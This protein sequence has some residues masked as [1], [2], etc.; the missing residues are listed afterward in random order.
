M[1]DVKEK[2]L[3]ICKEAYDKGMVIGS[4]GNV[5]IRVGEKVII[6]PTGYNLGKLRKEDLVE[7]KLDGTVIKGG[8][9]SQET[10]FHLAIYNEISHVE[11][12]VHVHSLASICAGILKGGSE[13]PPYTPNFVKKVGGAPLVPFDVPGSEALSQ[14]VVK[15]FIAKKSKAVLLQNHGVVSIGKSLD[16]ALAIAEE[17][18]ENAKIH[19]TLK[20]E[21]RA[22]TQ[23]EILLIDANYGN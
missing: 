3:A 11:A 5:S 23:E 16:E 19:M 12:I 14:K 22:L 8:K 17:V 4:G 9:P 21:G 7:L 1:V 13:M 15:A 2:V 10:P 20:G 18:E 6:T